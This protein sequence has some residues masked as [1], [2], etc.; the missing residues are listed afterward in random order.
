M[1]KATAYCFAKRAFIDR[2]K[3]DRD[4]NGIVCDLKKYHLQSEIRTPI[5]KYMISVHGSTSSGKSS[6]INDIIGICTQ[7]TS[8]SEQDTFVSIIYTVDE[9]TFKAFSEGRRKSYKLE[10]LG[11]LTIEQLKSDISATVVEDIR[12]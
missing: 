7:A 3:M 6:F 8:E 4:Y 11:S 1:W 9:S 12:C 10:D 2:E 5:N